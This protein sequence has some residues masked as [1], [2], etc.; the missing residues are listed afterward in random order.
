MMGTFRFVWLFAFAL[1]V[2]AKQSVDDLCDQIPTVN[3]L[4]L[5]AEL[6]RNENLLVFY[7]LPVK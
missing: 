1:V 2:N 7:Y 4:Q 5:E 3:A 6:S